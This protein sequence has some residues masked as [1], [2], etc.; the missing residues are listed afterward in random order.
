MH[1]LSDSDRTK[2]ATTV[3]GLKASTEYDVVLFFKSASRGAATVWTLP[4][5]GSLTRVSDKDA[6]KDAVLSGTPVYLTLAGSPYEIGSTKPVKG[7]QVF[8]TK[9]LLI[10]TS[11]HLEST[12][13]ASI[14]TASAPIPVS[15]NTTAANSPW[16]A[17]SS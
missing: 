7:S 17:S 14:S 8:G 6:L 1:T 15:S 13:R 12:S 4:S 9:L 16:A 11:V 3:P 2:A 10:K 5:A